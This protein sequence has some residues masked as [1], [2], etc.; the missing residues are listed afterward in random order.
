M[1]AVR[2]GTARI[3]DVPPWEDLPALASGLPDFPGAQI[4]I[5]LPAA[6]LDEERGRR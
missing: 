6:D 2:S 3:A 1:I 4:T 5:I